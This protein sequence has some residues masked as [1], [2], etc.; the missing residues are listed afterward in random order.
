[1]CSR[2]GLFSVCVY[3]SAAADLV[4]VRPRMQLPLLSSIR[5]LVCP[6]PQDTIRMYRTT[7][8]IRLTPYWWLLS[9]VC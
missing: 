1:M 6:R 2:T 4:E 5:V 7:A 8:T 3:L 9:S